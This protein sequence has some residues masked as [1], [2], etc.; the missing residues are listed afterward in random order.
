[1]R[2]AS[3]PVL[4]LRAVGGGVHDSCTFQCGLVGSFT[5]PGIESRH[6]IEGTN[7][8]YCLIRKTLASG[9]N[10]I[11][12]VPKRKKF[13]PKWDSN[14]RPSGRCPNPLGH[15]SPGSGSLF[16]GKVGSDLGEEKPDGPFSSSELGE[17]PSYIIRLS[18][19]FLW[20]MH[21]KS[22]V[23]GILSELSE[24]PT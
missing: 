13:L 20:E 21:H 14:H 15:R 6:Q 7:G 12:K 9:V 23:L 4:M 2:R 8:F 16:S 22:T 17:Y 3:G 19:R 11:A 1:M 5:S 24:D 18:R 10:G